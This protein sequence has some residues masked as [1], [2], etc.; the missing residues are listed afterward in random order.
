MAFDLAEAKQN[1][2]QDGTAGLTALNDGKYDDAI[3]LFTRAL[4]DKKLTASD[5]AVA[6]YDRGLAHLKKG[7]RQS[8]AADFRSALK[9]KPGDAEIQQHLAI[10]LAPPPTP[11]QLLQATW[12]PLAT[13][14]G[15]IWLQS[16]KG[17]EFYV[18]Y[19]W[20]Q[21]GIVISYSGMDR[22]GNP[23]AGQYQLDPATRK[24]TG[25]TIYRG[26][27]TT[28]DV[29]IASD[30]YVEVVMEKDTQVRQVY[31]RSGPTAFVVKAEALKK[32]IWKPV[33]TATYTQATPEMVLALGWTAA[34]AQANN[35]GFMQQL[36]AGA[37]AG[38]QEGL[39]EG[40]RDAAQARAR[41]ALAPKAYP[42]GQPGVTV[43]APQ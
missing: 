21:P 28:G 36:K 12:G 17:P 10:A 38:F 4:A 27:I 43:S 19:Q 13:L 8:A 20:A 26:K 24:I 40:V 32:G 23:I 9:L 29:E 11:A 1:G 25:Q 3:R 22:A 34:P 5:R 15:Q 41:G 2:V 30:G 37:M 18:A 16:V 14:P 31:S 39:R 7:Q 33:R 42:K 35:V 6:Y